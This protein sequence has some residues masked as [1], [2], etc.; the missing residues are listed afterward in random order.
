MGELTLDRNGLPAQLHAGQRSAG[1]KLTELLAG[2]IE[3]RAWREQPS[4]ASE[5]ASA[6]NGGG[7]ARASLSTRQRTKKETYLHRI[8]VWKHLNVEKLNA[9][10]DRRGARQAGGPRSSSTRGQP[11]RSSTSNLAKKKLDAASHSE[12]ETFALHL[13][14]PK[15]ARACFVN[16][17]LPENPPENDANDQAAIDTVLSALVFTT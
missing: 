5:N 2:P 10:D 7:L 8:A 13:D 11:K 6:N 12:L 17:L 16:H 3:F 4:S 15:L 14:A 1:G 9:D